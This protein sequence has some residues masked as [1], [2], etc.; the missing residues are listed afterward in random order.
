[1]IDLSDTQAAFAGVI[2]GPL[3]M[4]FGAFISDG[5]WNRFYGTR[6]EEGRIYA[7][8]LR[9]VPRT[10]GRAFFLVVGLLL[11]LAGVLLFVR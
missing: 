5:F 2:I 7:P 6:E 8:V 11:T 3:L 1:V 4:L 10:V 9:R